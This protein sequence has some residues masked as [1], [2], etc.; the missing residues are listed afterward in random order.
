MEFEQVLSCTKS[1]Y[2][3][4]LLSIT[5]A[6]DAEGVYPSIAPCFDLSELHLDCSPRL[7][8]PT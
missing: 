6:E 8:L 3:C 2:L 1:A 7:R 4:R 5:N